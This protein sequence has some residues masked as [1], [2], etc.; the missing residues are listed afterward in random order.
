MVCSD[1]Y[2]Y[3]KIARSVY[4]KKIKVFLSRIPRLG[5]QKISQIVPQIRRFAAAEKFGCIFENKI[6]YICQRNVFEVF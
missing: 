6:I 5:M 1:T 2:A 4:A 3:K